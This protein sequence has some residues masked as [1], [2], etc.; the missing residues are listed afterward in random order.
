MERINVRV[1]EQLKK[2][3][4]NEARARGVRP[5]DIVREAL[6]EH[7]R[8]RANPEL[9]RYRPPHWFYWGVRRHAVRPQ[10]QP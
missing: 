6:E 2:T 4:E 3:L 1:N 5:S 7:I 9:P 10:H 8:A